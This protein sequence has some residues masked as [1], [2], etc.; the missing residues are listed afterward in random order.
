LRTVRGC[1]QLRTLSLVSSKVV[2]LT[3]LQ[4][5]AEL[6]SL[7]ISN[8]TEL[9]SLEGLQACGKLKDACVLVTTLSP[10]SSCL[11]LKKVSMRYLHRVH[12]VAPLLA[13]AELERLSIYGCQL[14]S[15]ELAALK[16]ALPRLVIY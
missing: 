15:S 5:C 13:C 6:Q 8:C 3:P 4:G 1:T 16:A 9:K 10:L 7:N 14:P 11:R 2:D 12:S